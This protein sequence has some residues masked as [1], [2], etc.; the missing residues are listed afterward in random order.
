MIDN[1]KDFGLT[2]NHAKGNEQSF[3]VWMDI[4]Y[5]CHIFMWIQGGGSVSLQD[6]AIGD[7]GCLY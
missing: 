7:S 6:V 1:N 4:N 5:P 2:V 3:Q